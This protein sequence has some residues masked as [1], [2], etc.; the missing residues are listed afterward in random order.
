MAKAKK[1]PKKETE[2][3]FFE[4]ALSFAKTLLGAIVVVMIING[5]LVA[6][7]VVPTGSMERTVM[8]GDFLFVNKFLY[9]PTTP[10]VLPFLNIPLP[11]YKFPGIKKPELGDVIVFIYPGDRDDLEPKEF[12]YYLK[13][14]L[15]VGGDKI[16]IKDKKVFVNNKEFKLPQNGVLMPERSNYPADF[17]MGAGF[18]TDNYGPIKVPKTGDKI[19]LNTDNVHQWITFIKREGHELTFDYNDIY[20]DGKKS[21]TYTVKNNYVFGMGDNRDNSEDSRAWGFIPEENV[22]GTPLI[23]YWSWDTNLPLS[24]FMDKLIS[25]RWS[26]IGTLIN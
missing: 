21:N 15:G 19:E 10:Q 18:T 20:I 24:Q 8:T 26:R 12:T 7:F 23:V 9:G 3:N 6:S 1:I 14:C 16:E 25:I 2:L 11:F 13:R 17:P 4:E 22:I 5:L